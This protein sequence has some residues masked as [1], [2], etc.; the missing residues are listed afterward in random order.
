MADFHLT[1]LCA[2]PPATVWDV[3]TDFAAYGDW[4]PLTRMVVDRGSPRL[5]WGFAGVSGL[6]R[7]GFSDSMLVTAWTP[8]GDDGRGSFRVVKTG[9]LLGGWAEVRVA[10]EGAGTR[11]D[12]LEDVV[13]R[14]LPF[15]RLFAPLLSRASNWLYG[16]AVDAMLARAE[17]RARSNPGGAPSV[18]PEAGR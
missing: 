14:P 4:M 2:A 13:V 11:L 1:R 17:Q 12:W 7:V 15:K 6:G 3:V 16:R 8:P 5:G 10:P 18:G 9:R